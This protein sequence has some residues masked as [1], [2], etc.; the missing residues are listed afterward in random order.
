MKSG[1]NRGLYS[2]GEFTSGGVDAAESLPTVLSANGSAYV[3]GYEIRKI[4]TTF[5]DVDKARDFETH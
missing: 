1:N 2:S 4:G 3:K 5:I